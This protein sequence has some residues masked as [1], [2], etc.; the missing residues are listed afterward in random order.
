MLTAAPLAFGDARAPKQRAS[1]SEDTKLSKAL[2]LRRKKTTAARPTISAP[3]PQQPPQRDPG[4]DASR[5]NSAWDAQST[6]SAATN[7]SVPGQGQRLS[8]SGDGTKT[9]DLVR[10]RYSTRFAGGVLDLGGAAPPL[11][12][13][14]TQYLHAQPRRSQDSRSPS[15]D[16]RSASRGRGPLRVDGRALKDPHLEAEGYVR[17]ILAEADA[18]D[19]ARFTDELQDVRAQTGGELRQNVYQNR[20]QFIKISREAEKLKSEMRV[21]RGLMGELT[22]ALSHAT[23][24]GGIGELGAPGSRLSTSTAGRRGGAA[25]RSSVANLEALWSTHLQTLW[26]RVEGSQKSLPALPGRHIV[27]ESQRWVE[28]NAATW[29]PRR[30]VALVLL[31]DHLLVACEKKRADTQPQAQQAHTNGH[32]PQHPPQ[33]TQTVLVA[34]HCFPLHEVSLA[35]ITTPT[36]NPHH[37][38]SRHRNIANAINIRA[39]TESLTYATSDPTEK[40]GILVAFRKAQEDLRKALAAEHGLR[41]KKVEEITSHEGVEKSA[42]GLAKANSVL[43]DVDGRQQSLRWV[44]TQIDGLDI[45]IALQRFEESVSRLEKLRSLAR[46][47]KGNAAATE[48]I[49]AKL[50]ERAARLGSNIARQLV[51]T[52]GGLERTKKNVA[53]LLRLGFEELARSKYLDARTETIRTTTRQLPFTG[54]LPVYLHALS[55]TTFTLLLHSFRTFSVAFP[56][57]GAGSFV[58]TWGMERVEEFN[59]VLARQL[60]AVETGSEVWEE[61]VSVVKQQA[62]GLGEVGVDFG[63]LVG[64]GVFDQVGGAGGSGMGRSETGV[65]R[66]GRERGERSRSRRR[67][68]RKATGESEAA[69]AG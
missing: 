50:D 14:P 18:S 5:N 58:V 42:G 60:E 11:P 43:L 25:N 68:E 62:E 32:N 41:E 51:Q 4:Q 53:W 19:I 12:G 44:E 66:R 57:S 1:M 6:R 63:G 29:K 15:R 49:T 27:L 65:G 59:A 24:A 56:A 2:S 26:K 39:G 37:E 40:A 16:T 20:T 30:R 47:I 28:L 35:D 46:A 31:N 13:L 9:S 52:S 7:L 22:Q 69:A 38:S 17:S 23:S 67:A 64:K 34:A 3:L 54:I 8:I 36:P 10:R 55:Y 33:S 45:D 61:C 48:S 21:L